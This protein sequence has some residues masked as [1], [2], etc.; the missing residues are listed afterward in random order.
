MGCSD[1]GVK[2]GVECTIPW[3]SVNDGVVGASMR[4]TGGGR[5]ANP[6]V[7]CWGDD[8]WDFQGELRRICASP[9]PGVVGDSRRGDTVDGSP[10]SG[11]TGEREVV[12][13]LSGRVGGENL[14]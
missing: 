1:V 11:R 5:A 4:S 14:T 2:A 3:F 13:L 9:L 12:G 7:T 8:R 10:P 6:R